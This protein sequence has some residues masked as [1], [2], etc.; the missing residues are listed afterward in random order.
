VADHVELRHGQGQQRLR[1]GTTDP[2]T[3]G[4]DPTPATG[5]GRGGA[6]AQDEGAAAQGL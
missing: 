5:E 2:V 4:P 6:M 3:G 1:E